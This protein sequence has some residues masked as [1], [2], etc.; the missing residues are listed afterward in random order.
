MFG[1][2]IADLISDRRKPEKF[3]Y[4]S[5]KSV[6]VTARDCHPS[7]YAHAVNVHSTVTIRNIISSTTII[8]YTTLS[9]SY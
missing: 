3:L 7:S 8:D 6:E 4:P 2:F 1:C 9:N 5:Q